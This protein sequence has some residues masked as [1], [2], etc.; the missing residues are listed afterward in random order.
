MK[1]SYIAPRVENPSNGEPGVWDTR[2]PSAPRP[3]RMVH[4]VSQ[5]SSKALGTWSP[6]PRRSQGLAT[7]ERWH[8]ENHRRVWTW[9]KAMS[10][11]RGRGQARRSLKPR[12]LGRP[13]GRAVDRRGAAK[14]APPYKEG[15]LSP[16]SAGPRSG[17]QGRREGSTFRATSPLAWPLASGPSG[18]WGS[19]QMTSGAVF[20]PPS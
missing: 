18:F 15:T 1:F 8:E 5:N 17:D 6:P 19:E 10:W 2:S 11:C 20:C 12:A 9:G 7:G 3:N 13:G 16:W 14:E 4:L